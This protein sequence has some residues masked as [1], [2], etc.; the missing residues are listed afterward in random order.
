MLVK[1]NL[2]LKKKMQMPSQIFK[3]NIRENLKTK[4][5]ALNFRMFDLKLKVQKGICTQKCWY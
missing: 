4:K 3:K 5:M 1:L 2:K